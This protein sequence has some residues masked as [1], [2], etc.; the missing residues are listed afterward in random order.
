MKIV[1]LVGIAVICLASTAFAYDMSYLCSVKPHESHVG[2]INLPAGKSTV[3]VTA[4]DYKNITCRFIDPGTGNNAFLA[5]NVP[6]CLANAN[7][8]LPRRLIVKITNETDEELA[9]V[10][11]VTD[12][13]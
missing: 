11:Q 7:L 8:T 5:T 12:S 4:T 2:Q 9:V 10:T 3:R 6:V 13:K 1:S